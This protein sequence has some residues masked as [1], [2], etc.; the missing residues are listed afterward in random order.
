MA[1]TSDGKID[2]HDSYRPYYQRNHLSPQK[3]MLV[4]HR[5]AYQRASDV[6][7]I[8][9]IAA[10][11][12]REASTDHKLERTHKRHRIVLMARAFRIR[13]RQ[14]SHHHRAGSC[15]EY[16]AIEMIQLLEDQPTIAGALDPLPGHGMISRIPSN[17]NSHEYDG[18]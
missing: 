16:Q 7:A 4:Q 14:A 15:K 9:E 10:C 11:M 2:P 18:I 8:N 5:H 6:A 3:S 12:R 17:N 1:P 13:L